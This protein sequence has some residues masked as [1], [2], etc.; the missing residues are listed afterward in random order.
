MDPNQGP[1]SLLQFKLADHLVGASSKEFRNGFGHRPYY[2]VKI[3]NTAPSRQYDTL[4]QTA[5]QTIS[6]LGKAVAA[7]YIAPKFMD[8]AQGGVPRSQV[9]AQ[10]QAWIGGHFKNTTLLRHLLVHDLLRITGITAGQNHALAICARCGKRGVYSEPEFIEEPYDFGEF[11]ADGFAGTFH[12]R[13]EP[14]ELRTLL[15]VLLEAARE[16]RPRPSTFTRSEDVG[17]LSDAE[18]LSAVRSLMARR[19]GAQLF[20]LISSPLV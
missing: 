16:A 10:S 8:G 2:R 17:D 19:H 15:R 20:V 6:R 13:L 14:V 4:R 7:G 3:V 18:L 1:L 12:D 9:R 11:T 5:V